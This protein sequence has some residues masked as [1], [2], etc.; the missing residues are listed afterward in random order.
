M[1]PADLVRLKFAKDLLENPGL[2]AKLT[3]VIGLPFEKAFDYLPEKWSG[4]IQNI[5]KESLTHALDVA[6]KTINHNEKKPSSNILHKFLVAASGG[7]GGAFGLPALAIELPAT[8]VIMFR[9]IADIA[10]SEGEDVQRIETRLACLEVFALGGSSEKDNAAESGYYAVKT[11][12]AK[13][14]SEAAKYI[15]EKGIAEEGAPVLIRLITT[16]ASRFG[17]VVSQKA[18]VSAVPVIG[19]A[20]GALIN[21]IFMDHFQNMARGHF[22]MRGL[23]RKYGSETIQRKYLT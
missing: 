15:V 13:Q 5:T 11:L 20:G 16:I 10:R 14:V 22:I 9:S 18:A 4:T 21:S 8:T 23:E 3:N 7:I 19:A 17:V 1:T 6:V 2:A 12:L